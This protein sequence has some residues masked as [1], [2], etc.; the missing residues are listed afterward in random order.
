MKGWQ[1]FLPGDQ[2]TTAPTTLTETHVVAFAGLTGDFYFLHTDEVAA[3]QTQFGG[4]IVHGPLIYATA[5]GQAF[6]R[7]IFDDAIIAF[8][9]VDELRHMAPCLIGATVRTQVRVLGSRPTSDGSRGVTT[10]LYTVLDHDD[11]ELMTARLTFLM[12]STSAPSQQCLVKT[13]TG[14]TSTGG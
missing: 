13:D 12:R 6:Q 9:G 8:L 4:R 14:A 7:G 10:M 2:W 5:V 11:V 3:S 1:D